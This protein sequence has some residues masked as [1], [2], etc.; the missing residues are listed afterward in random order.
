MPTIVAVEVCPLAIPMREA[1][2]TSR[3]AYGTM[4]YAIVRVTLSDGATGYGE[5]RESVHITGETQGGIIEAVRTLLGPALAG[6]EADDVEGVHARMAAAADFNACAKSGIDMALHDALGHSRGMPVAVLLGGTVRGPIASSKAISVGETGAMVAQA[7]RFVEAGF[8]TVKIKTGADPVAER[9]AIAA[10]RAECGPGL[11]IKL[12]ANQAWSLPEAASFLREV[13][14][15]GIEMVEQPLP[16][17]DLVGSAELRRRTPIPVM[18]DE[19]V[20]SPQD[21]YRAIAAGACD[22]VNIKLLK[23]GGLHPAAKLVAVC[24]SAGIACQIGTLDTSIGSA[25][26]A[27]LVHARSN[28][29]FAEINGPSR[30]AFDLATGFAIENGA[31]QV[32][33]RPGLGLEI[34]AD[35]LSF[36]QPVV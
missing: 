10:I 12:D 3:H 26:A 34:L 17:W 2:A 1:L 18:L 24:E 36:T 35:R 16:A 30:I 23:T 21:A 9:T 22:Y 20:H 29:R 33:A 32:T 13:E 28:I 5:A 11:K 14:G 25:A 8:G 15:F 6:H 4:G 19:G 27:H 7:R 31:A